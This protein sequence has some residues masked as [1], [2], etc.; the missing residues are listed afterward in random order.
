MLDDCVSV[1][2][3]LQWWRPETNVGWRTTVSSLGKRC[4]ESLVHKQV[5][6]VKFIFGLLN[7][8]LPAE[9]ATS[10]SLVGLWSGNRARRAQCVPRDVT[11]HRLNAHSCKES[12]DIPPLIAVWYQAWCQG[13][14]SGSVKDKESVAHHSCI[15]PVTSRCLW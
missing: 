6:H 4:Y 11:W 13:V 14:A 5:V 1:I 10:K 2:Y 9:H 15:E 3:V 12:V 7:N 8:T